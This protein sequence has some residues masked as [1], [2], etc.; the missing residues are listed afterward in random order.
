MDTAR[1]WQVVSVAT[2]IAGLGVGS[3]LVGRTPSTAIPTIDLDLVAAS[4]APDDEPFAQRPLDGSEIVPPIIREDQLEIPASGE[5]TEADRDLA[6]GPDTRRPTTPAPSLPSPDAPAPAPTPPAPAPDPADSPQDDVD[7]D[8]ED[9][10]Q[11]Q[12]EDED[13]EDGDEHEDDE[14]DGEDDG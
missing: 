2:A 12:D 3:L 8:D 9:D 10:D 7:E 11:H 14:D 5:S 1:R 13:D 6:D 4:T